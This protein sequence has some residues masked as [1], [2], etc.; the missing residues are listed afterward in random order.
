MLM[1]RNIRTRLPA[2][3]FI[4]V[5]SQ[6]TQNKQKKYYDKGAKLLT[7]LQ[8]GQI[9]RIRND[10]DWENKGEILE[11]LDERSYNVLTE[12]GNIL[13]RNRRHL[14]QTN[15]ENKE[16]SNGP[17]PSQRK[18][19]DPLEADKNIMDSQGNQQEQN[20][21]DH[22]SSKRTRNPPKRLIDEM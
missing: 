14:L 11:K 21:A 15:E 12:S 19:S 7:P 17:G 9:V 22:A 13:R 1:N 10:K 8:P 5:K 4:N 3:E 20:V 18:K 6:S 2:A 16:K